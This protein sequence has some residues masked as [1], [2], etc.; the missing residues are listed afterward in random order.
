[1]A[2]R[3]RKTG[4]KPMRTPSTGRDCLASFKVS[5]NREGVAEDSE[6]TKDHWRDSRD[7]KIVGNKTAKVPLRKSIANTIIPAFFPKIRKVLVVPVFPE[8]CSRRLMLKKI[9]PIHKPEGIEPNKYA[10]TSKRIVFIIVSL[11]QKCFE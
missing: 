9:F 4:E 7:P 2:K 1:M 6:K 3:M 8:P 5:K 11:Y 10:N